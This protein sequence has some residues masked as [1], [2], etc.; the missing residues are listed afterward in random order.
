VEGLFGDADVL[1]VGE[2]RRVAT[3]QLPFGEPDHLAEGVVHVDEPVIDVGEAHRRHVALEGDTESQLHVSASA[4][5]G[6][7]H[8]VVADGAEHPRLALEDEWRDCEVDWQLTA[9]LAEHREV[10]VAPDERGLGIDRVLATH[11]ELHVAQPGRNEHLDVLSHQILTGVA[12][13]RRQ[14]VVDVVHHAPPVQESDAVWQ[15]FE[16]SI[17][18]NRM[19]IEKAREPD[20]P[21]RCRRRGALDP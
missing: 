7:L 9:V 4:L 6:S 21:L 20:D 2:E 1:G 11:H 5:E 17:P 8:A 12:R 3:E 14:M 15:R 16:E 10:E 19:L 13:H 18:G